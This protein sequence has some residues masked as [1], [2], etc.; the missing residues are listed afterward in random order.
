[1]KLL[2]ESIPNIVEEIFGLEFTSWSLDFPLDPFV[3]MENKPLSGRNSKFASQVQVC[4]KVIV[5]QRGQVAL[6]DLIDSPLNNFS[7]AIGHNL[8]E[9]IKDLSQV[10]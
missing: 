10:Y 2:I 3:Y 5:I 1:M 4:R 7:V 8:R 6:F 9:S